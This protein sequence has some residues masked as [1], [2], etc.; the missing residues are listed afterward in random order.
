MRLLA[1]ESPS[2]WDTSA[3][4]IRSSGSIFA[5]TEIESRNFDTP[6]PMDLPA[7]RDSAQLLQPRR[8]ALSLDRTAEGGRRERRVCG[9]GAELIQTSS[10]CSSNV[11]LPALQ[12]RFCEISAHSTA[13][14]RDQFATPDN[15]ATDWATGLHRIRHPGRTT[16]RLDDQS[17]LGILSATVNACL[18][19]KSAGS[20]Y[21]RAGLIFL[22][23]RQAVHDGAYTAQRSN[24]LKNSGGQAAV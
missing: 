7:T 10:K 6:V 13:A 18:A 5:P 11:G 1:C 21:A 22:H 8:P 3:A 14:G 23:W 24:S 15:G 2:T 16:V 4:P 9:R 17:L 20:S 19:R 12:E